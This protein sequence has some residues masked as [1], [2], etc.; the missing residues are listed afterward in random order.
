VAGP[1]QTGGMSSRGSSE[2][3]DASPDRALDALELTI[4][5]VRGRGRLAGPRDDGAKGEKVLELL[6]L[7]AP[8][9]PTSRRA[10]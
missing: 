4:A 3:A 9:A 1:G 5:E 6:D 2:R 10:S 7:L 8:A